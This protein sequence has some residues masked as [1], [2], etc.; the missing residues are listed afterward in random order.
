MAKKGMAKGFTH[1]APK[2]GTMT[3]KRGKTSVCTPSNVKALG[4]KGK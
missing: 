3:V 4:S 1:G 2:Q